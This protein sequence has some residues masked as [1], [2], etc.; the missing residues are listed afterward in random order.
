MYDS[1]IIGMGISGVS[2]AIYLKRAGLNVLILEGAV[3]GGI[4]NEIPKIEN[5]PGIKEI[6]G[7]DLASNLFDSIKGLNIDYKLESVKEVVFGDVKKV[8]TKSGEYT[9]KNL[10]I[11]SGRRPRMLGIPH[12]EEYLGR[13]ISTCALCD[14]NFFKNKDVIVVGGGSSA[15]TE[16]LY[17]A[18]IVNKVTVIHRRDEFRA[19][20]ILEEQVRN[21]S[22]IE[23]VTNRTVKDLIINDDTIKGVILDNEEKIEAA[24]IFLAVGYIP[25]T[26]FLKD[27][28]ELDN[29]Y[30][31]VD[32]NYETNIKGVYACGDVIKKN[33]YQIV[34]AAS[35]GACVGVNI[36]RNK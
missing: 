8:I 18:N 20:N 29:A 13:G 9:C 2:C 30:I 5:Y 11:A 31:V 21:K 32:E 22:N 27:N 28:I 4:I 17:L 7:P 24:G 23:L 14:G 19:E 12:E 10:V 25:N 16:S 33:I 6:A 35:E 36:A 15:L 26:E 1:I 3:P 34:T